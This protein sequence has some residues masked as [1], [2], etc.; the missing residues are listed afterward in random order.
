MSAPILNTAFTGQTPAVPGATSAAAGGAAAGFQALLGAFF[1]GQDGLGAQLFAGAGPAKDAAG[2]AAATEEVKD[3]TVD[4][5]DAEAQML[6]GLLGL[7]TAPTTLPALTAAAAPDAG[8][9]GATP[10]TG[11]PTPGA[12]LAADVIADA[13]ASATE[14]ASGDATPVAAPV[15]TPALHADTPVTTNPVLPTPAPVAETPAAPATPTT[16][17]ATQVAAMEGAIPPAEQPKTAATERHGKAATTTTVQ[18]AATAGEDA[19]ALLATRAPTPTA[20][21]GGEQQGAGGQTASDANDAL[22][23]T[24]VSRREPQA[25]T[26]DAQQPQI[27]TSTAAPA[28]TTAPAHA[29]PPARATPETVAH[30]A[31]QIARHSEGGRSTQFDIELNPAGL[32]RVDV[33]LEI[34]AHGQITAAMSFDNAASAAE[35]RGRAAELHRALEQAGFDVSSGGLSFDV[36]GDRGQAGQGFA[37]RDGAWDAWRGRAF[38]AALNIDAT[39]EAAAASGLNLQRRTNSGV[40]IRI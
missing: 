38:Q 30:L 29:A 35:V 37:G 4:G 22:A 8:Q 26:P 6:A 11:A 20:P 33:R 28:A 14:T 9:G 21:T 13:L 39:A 23:A 12:A 18:A 17:A 25:D 36:A 24:E 7:P 19:N 32:G 5:A 40:D 10:S 2:K 27:T 15:K 16:D 3:G 31:A 34:S 1:G